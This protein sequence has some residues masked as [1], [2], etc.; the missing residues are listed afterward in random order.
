MGAC[1]RTW[2]HNL[3]LGGPGLL[4]E[5]GANQRQR[6]AAAHGL[7]PVPRVHGCCGLASAGLL[8]HAWELAERVVG[9]V[10]GQALSSGP[11]RKLLLQQHRH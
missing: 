1:A 10:L 4:A 11:P 6:R 2:K 5:R 9:L 3:G 7:H 8:R